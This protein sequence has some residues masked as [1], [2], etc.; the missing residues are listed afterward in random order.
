MCLHC[1]FRGRGH[2]GSSGVSMLEAVLRENRWGHGDRVNWSWGGTRIGWGDGG[3]EMGMEVLC[4]TD[5]ISLWLQPR[6]LQHW[7]GTGT[8]QR[9]PWEPRRALK[10]EPG[11]SPA[12]VP[13]NT[14][15][16]RCCHRL[17]SSL[18]PRGHAPTPNHAHFPAPTHQRTH[19]GVLPGHA[20]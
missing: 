18:E 5:P 8:V 1:C 9:C 4:G 16:L 19:Q 14:I 11:G 10:T 6:T 13:T 3:G 15:K 20:P 7:K 2:R 17:H 12:R